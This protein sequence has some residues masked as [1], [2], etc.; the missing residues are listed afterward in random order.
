MEHEGPDEV[1][2]PFEHCPLGTRSRKSKKTDF[3]LC[4]LMTLVAALLSE[5]CAFTAGAQV[6]QDGSP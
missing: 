2:A 5:Y 1:S 4:L 6:S 3:Q